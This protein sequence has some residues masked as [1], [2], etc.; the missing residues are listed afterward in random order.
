MSQTSPSQQKDTSY[1]NTWII[2]AVQGLKGPVHA[3]IHFDSFPTKKTKVAL[4]QLR[5]DTE[6]AVPTAYV[7]LL[8][9]RIVHSVYS[10]T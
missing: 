4:T 8:N 10:H 5:Q 7:Y 6:S 3:Y 2:I 9:K 1:C